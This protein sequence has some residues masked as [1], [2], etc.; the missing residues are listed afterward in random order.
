MTNGN[1]TFCGDHFVIYIYKYTY[2]YI[3]TNIYKYIQAKSICGTPETTKIVY[4]NY[5]SIKQSEKKGEINEEGYCVV[6]N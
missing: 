3:Q 6:Y 1:W 4:A 5:T 2:K